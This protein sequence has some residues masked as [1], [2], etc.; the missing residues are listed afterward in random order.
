[1]ILDFRLPIFDCEEHLHK[2]LSKL[3]LNFVSDNR[4][5]KSKIENG[6]GLLLSLSHL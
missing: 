1:M 3:F 4:N 6:W 2:K 5:L